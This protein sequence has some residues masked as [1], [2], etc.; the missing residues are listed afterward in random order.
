MN[1]Q[2]KSRFTGKI[3]FEKDADSM[4]LCVEAAVES[5]ANLRDADL[6]GADLR[7]AD[8]RGAD[9]WDADLRDAD[10]RGAD[11]RRADLRGANLRGADGIPKIPDIHKAVHAAITA[12]GCSLDMGDWHTCE[13]THC[14]AGWVVHLAGEGG[15]VLE[16]CLGTPAAA[17]LIYYASDPNL[18]R[19][20]DFYCTDSEAMADIERM[21]GVGGAA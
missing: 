9:L 11:L 19:V 17:A 18:E 2:I 15:R 12:E 6:R 5:K 14:R 3:L 20:P 7:R 13:T 4:R 8:L 21:A 16:G 1:F 10:L